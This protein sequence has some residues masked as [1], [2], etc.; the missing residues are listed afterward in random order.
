[1]KEICAALK[2]KE[3]L[4]DVDNELIVAQKKYINLETIGYDII[5]I[6]EEQEDLYKKYDKKIYKD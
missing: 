6:V 3:F 5:S 2:I 4:K 1:M